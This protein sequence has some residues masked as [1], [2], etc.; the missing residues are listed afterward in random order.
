MNVPCRQPETYTLRNANGMSAT[1]VNPGLILQSL[2]VPLNGT[3]REVCLGFTSAESYQDEQYLQHYPYLGAVIGR[4][5]NRVKNATFEWEGKAHRL[6]SND[7]KHCLHGGQSGYDKKW[8][9]CQKK[10]DS[11]ITFHLHSPAMDENFP[12]AIDIWAEFWLSEQNELGV[13]FTTSSEKP[14]PVNLTWHPYFNL[15]PEKKTIEQHWLSVHADHYL[16]SDEYTVITGRVLEIS[17]IFKGI[18][19][20]SVLEPILKKNKGIDTSFVIREY[21]TTALVHAGSLTSGD[22]L[23]RMDIL[24]NNPIVHVYTGQHLP[25]LTLPGEEPL[26]PYKGICF[27]CQLYTD[28]VN[29]PNFPRLVPSSR[30]PLVQETV[31]AFKS[32]PQSYGSEEA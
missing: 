10:T 6:A 7:G 27:E 4:M 24:T 11:S 18:H 15:D 8:W 29:Q 21:K 25:E 32:N 20:P 30:N 28:Y 12:E 14:T 19:M 1:F 31:Y 16:E 5:A 23:L 3:F 9:A 22:Q 2:I 26:F 17:T 13:R